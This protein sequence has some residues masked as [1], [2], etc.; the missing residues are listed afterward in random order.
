MPSAAAR[1]AFAASLALGASSC[2]ND[3]P[4]AGDP[5]RLAQGAAPDARPRAGRIDLNV[6]ISPSGEPFHGGR[7][8]PYASAAWFA[9]ADLDHDGRLTLAEF[10]ADA[11]RAFAL[12]DS[13]KDGVVDAF[14]VQNYEQAIA[15]E[16]MPRIEALRAGE[17]MDDTL[18]KK[19]GGS[20]RR[21]GEPSSGRSA[22]RQLAGDRVA[23]G[24]GLYGMLAEPEPLTAADADL[25]GT[26]TRTEWL[27]RTDRRFALLDTPGRGYLV[28][29]DLPKTQAQLLLERRRAREAAAR[30]RRPLASPQRRVS[31]TPSTRPAANADAADTPTAMKGLV[32]TVSRRTSDWSAAQS[33]AAE[34]ASAT[35]R[36]MSSPVD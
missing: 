13:N 11:L 24:G 25:S 30:G 19:R 22:G 18:F 1:I 8:D 6:F 28:L 16:I 17:G 29:A 4:P 35:F 3:A 5:P 33:R 12:Y 26:I 23:E 14:E 15:P 10:R 2:A 36:R 9:R 27:A 21:G 32:W 7:D 34:E 20:G 31:N